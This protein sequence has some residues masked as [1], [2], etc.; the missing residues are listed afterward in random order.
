MFEHVGYFKEY[1][2]KGKFIGTCK[3]LEKDREKVGYEGKIIEVLIED[4][5]TDNNRTIKKGETVAT[6][7]YPLC[8]KINRD[9]T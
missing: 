9:N 3:I 1:Y 2:V 6:L 8:G 4:I 5:I 7:L